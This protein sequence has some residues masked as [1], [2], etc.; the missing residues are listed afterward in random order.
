[1]DRAVVGLGRGKVLLSLVVERAL[2]PGH[3]LDGA[4]DG[5]GLEAGGSVGV[6]AVAQGVDGAE[7]SLRGQGERVLVLG[8]GVGAQPSVSRAHLLYLRLHQGLEQRVG[9]GGG[10][11]GRRH[12]FGR[13]PHALGAALRDRHHAG[14]HLVV[15]HCLVGDPCTRGALRHGGHTV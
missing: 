11:A 1:M 15:G 2:F 8:H 3:G 10:R 9:G 5:G 14:T 12:Q 4:R 7:R 13:A 6:Q